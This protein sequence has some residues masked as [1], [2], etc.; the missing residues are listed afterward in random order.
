MPSSAGRAPTPSNRSAPASRTFSRTATATNRKRGGPPGSEELTVE[1]PQVEVVAH[2]GDRITHR[3]WIPMDV[4]TGASPDAIDGDYGVDAISTASRTNEAG[5]IELA[6]TW[7]ATRAT[8]ATLSGGFHIE[9]PYRSW[10]L[11]LAVA[12]S[13]ADDNAVIAIS[14]QPIRRLAR[15]LRH[16][17]HAPRA[18]R[19]L[20][21][22]PQ[23]RHHAAAVTDDGRPPR[24]RRDAAERRPRQHLERRPARHRRLRRREAAE[25]PP[26]PRLR[27]PARAMAAMARR[28]A[29]LLSLLRRRLGRARALGRGR[30]LPA[31][32]PVAVAARAPIASTSRAA[33]RFFTTGAIADRATCARADSDLGALRR[34]HAWRRDR[35]RSCA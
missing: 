35:R 32:R 4:V 24:L 13:F 19:P 12:H 8:A 9:E 3:L 26:A 1:Q 31:R 22:Q 16:P 27:R 30:A 29:S 10:H 15:H 6:S 21:D 34:A 20:V 17:R 28:A 11:G 14:A 33:S 5:A 2:Q 25:L 7:Q 18:R 23:P